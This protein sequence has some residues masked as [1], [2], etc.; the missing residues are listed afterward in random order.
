MQLL[1]PPALPALAIAAGASA[2]VPAGG[3]GSLA[4]STTLI[5]VVAW[6]GSAWSQLGGS[7]GASTDYV[8]LAADY[9]LTSGTTE[10]KLF[11]ATAN[12]ALTLAAG[13]YRFDGLL[14]INAM[15]ATSG[16]AAIDILGAGTATCD[17]W[18]WD[19]VG[20]DNTNALNV[21]AAPTGSGA[22]GQQ[23]T[24]SAVTGSTGTAM[25]AR[26][27]GTFRIS[28]GGTLIPSITLVT[29]AAAVVKTGSYLLFQK[30]GESSAA[31][32]GSWS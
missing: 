26:I 16:N 27:G 29:A 32:S 13:T 20:I 25:R 8:K 4:W 11:N 6:N 24:S 15:S 28:A 12:G 19:V 5:A 14:F 31:T 10:Q 7:S 22:D 21:A 3:A 18:L 23:T 30:I 2:P 9:T 17:R 1:A